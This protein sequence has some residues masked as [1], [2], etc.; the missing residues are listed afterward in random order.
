MSARSSIPSSVPPSGAVLVLALAVRAAAGEANLVEHQSPTIGKIDF[1]TE[2]QPLLE[3]NCI[4]CHGAT[5]QK[6]GLRLDQSEFYLKGGRN[7]PVILP[8]DSTNSPL[9][10]L[11]ARVD[12]DSVMPPQGEGEPLTSGQVALLRAWIDQGAWWSPGEEKPTFSL[13]LAPAVGYTAVRG[14]ESKYRQLAWQN[15]QWRSGLE[16]FE[17]YEQVAPDT[18]YTL[19]GHVLTDDYL[20]TLLIE[21]SDKGFARFGFEQFRKYD[22]DTGG[23]YPLFTPPVFTLDRDLHLDLGRAWADFGLTLPDW[24]R[25]VVGYEYQYRNGEKATLQWGAVNEAGKV[26]N[27]YP[28]YKDIDD[29]TQI[30]K[31]D[32]DYEHSG[33][34]IEDE[35]RGE[36]TD[37]NTRQENVLS[38]VVSASLNAPTL[39]IPESVKQGWQAFQGANTLRLERQFRPWL[40]SSAGYLYSHVSGDADFTLDRASVSGGP[41]VSRYSAQSILLER[42]SQVANANALLGP[43]NK[44]SLMLGVQGEWTR[45]NG[46]LDGVGDFEDSASPGRPGFT[47]NTVTEI[48][49][50]VVDESALLRYT[51][52]PFTTLYTEARLQQESLSQSEDFVSDM[53]PPLPTFL[54]NSDAQSD[55]FDVRTGFDTSPRNWFKLGSSYR[56]RE[57]STTYGGAAYYP[58]GP[59]PGY[60][61]FITARDLTTQEVE[62]RL[63]VRANRWL[64]TTF[65]YRL[66]ATDYHTTTK[67]PPGAPLGGEILAGD[68]D[69]QI[70]SLNFTLT[71]WRRFNCFASLSYQE[72]TSTTVQDPTGAVVPYQGNT[73]NVLIHGRYALTIKTDLT[74]GY[75]FSS[76]D[77]QQDNFATGL[78]L[79][80]DYQSHG[81]QV[82]VISRCTKDL[83]AKLQYGYYHYAEPSSGGANDYAANVVFVSLNWRLN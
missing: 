13:Q 66:L 45:Q 38:N 10:Q 5:R 31:F 7:G 75:T 79:G 71:P 51:Q 27:I 65:T 73:W 4:R 74:A 34:R 21:K 15:D 39:Q 60:P 30:L 76:A 54:R 16:A 57:R 48:D 44:C 11:V 14:N 3:Q 62:A 50:V 29:H 35:F 12:P 72:L 40:F 68:F 77:Y 23:Y 36:W 41:L 43:W 82:G 61:T 37:S 53:P 69:T 49:K 8:G 2:I 28:A 52:L 58:I 42:Q 70:F 55:A 33:W 63:T 56:W 25:L 59:L 17:L 67:P 32:L 26:R 22:V 9:I 80:I 46:D 83:T 20:A 1:A 18:K 24:P 64:K 6:G 81:F 47:N 78:P 19:N